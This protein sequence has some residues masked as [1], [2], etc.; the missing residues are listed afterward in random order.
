MKTTRFAPFAGLIVL[1]LSGGLPAGLH[2]GAIKYDQTEGDMLWPGGRIPYVFKDDISPEQR[3]VF[4]RCARA[5]QRF[6]NLKFVGT[7]QYGIHQSPDGNFVE[8]Q[9][10]PIK[11][12]NFAWI[13]RS[14][15]IG[16]PEAKMQ[17]LAIHDWTDGIVVHEMGHMLG[18]IHEQQRDNRETFVELL[19]DN[20]LPFTGVNWD[21]ERATNYTP[22][23]FD[24]I[25]HYDRSQQRIWWLT[26]DRLTM[27]ARPPNEHRTWD[28]GTNQIQFSGDRGTPVGDITA[29]LSIGDRFT[30]RTVYGSSVLVKGRVRLPGGFGLRGVTVELLGN[31]PDEQHFAN[32]LTETQERVV[33]TGPDG[34]FEFLGVPVGNYILRATRPGYTFLLQDTPIYT[35]TQ[36]PFVQDFVV[37]NAADNIPPVVDFSSPPRGTMQT[38]YKGTNLTG[39]GYLATLD[40]TF[41]DP[42]GHGVEKIEIALDSNQQWWNWNLG[43]LDPS[44]TVFDPNKHITEP[45]LLGGGLWRLTSAQKWPISPGLPDGAYHLQARARDLSGNYSAWGVKQANFTIDH[46]A[47]TITIDGPPLPGDTFFDFTS[48]KLG[49]L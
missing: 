46:V 42:V 2:A 44:G 41:S 11:N 34:E 19:P 47:P 1:L 31:G 35:G 23:D 15:N 26:E 33:I 17:P 28:M 18:F 21:I 3:A 5:W 7:T 43:A 24:S 16:F 38:H 4:Y 48:A 6:A 12:V 14:G 27:R 8:V 49:G 40:G 22:Y 30:I 37:S 32:L 20:R 39:S 9:N 10:N 29:L 36:N 13:G 45:L 25:M